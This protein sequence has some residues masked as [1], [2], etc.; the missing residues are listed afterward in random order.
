MTRRHMIRHIS[1][2]IKQNEI[3]LTEMDD[4]VMAHNTSSGSNTHLKQN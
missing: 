4:L 3:K 2:K 1:Q